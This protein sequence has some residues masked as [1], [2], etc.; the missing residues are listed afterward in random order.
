VQPHTFSISPYYHGRGLDAASVPAHGKQQY[1]RYLERF[2]V[3]TVDVEIKFEMIPQ[4]G[5]RLDN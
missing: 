4:F 3:L 5:K 2:P 1:G